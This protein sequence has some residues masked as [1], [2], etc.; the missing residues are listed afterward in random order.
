MN[1]PR[2]LPTVKHDAHGELKCEN[3]PRR[4]RV[5][6][7]LQAGVWWLNALSFNCECGATFTRKVAN[8]MH[9][10]KGLK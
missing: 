8:L 10:K 7:C 6:D 5:N 3:C 4:M 2:P 1:N 9:T